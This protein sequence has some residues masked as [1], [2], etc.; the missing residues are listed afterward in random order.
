MTEIDIWLQNIM[1]FV[2]REHSGGGLGLDELVQRFLGA[3][4]DVGL[5]G[6]GRLLLPGAAE[7]ANV[8]PLLVHF[9]IALLTVFLVVEVFAM[10]LKK[11]SLENVASWLLYLGTLGALASV[12]A[13]WFAAQSIPHDSTVHDVME[14]HEMLGFSVLAVAVILSLWRLFAGAPVSAMGRAL[15]LLLAFV[16]VGLLVVGA[17]LGG[18]MV[19]KYGVAV[20]AVPQPHAHDHHADSHTH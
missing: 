5:S 19:Y 12:A 10:I 13:G 11:E 16:M 14:T 9:P 1:Q 2:L 6:L 4:S 17:D 15:H 18:M 8:H 20:K 7:M 3:I